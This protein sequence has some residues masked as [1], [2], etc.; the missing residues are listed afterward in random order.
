M[1]SR[2]LRTGRVREESSC[3]AGRRAAERHPAGTYGES[4]GAE[5]LFG[6]GPG[7]V[8]HCSE[9]VIGWTMRADGVSGLRQGGR[10]Q[11][12]GSP[13]APGRR[14]TVLRREVHGGDRRRR[15]RGR[16]VADA[17]PV[18]RAA[19]PHGHFPAVVH[20]DR[21]EVPAG[22]GSALL[23]PSRSYVSPPSKG[24]PHDGAPVGPARIDAVDL[25]QRL[26]APRAFRPVR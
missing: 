19:G 17:R 7:A 16:S 25:S 4:T 21:N 13:H 10:S 23:R 6:P 22:T 20:R 5:G 18:A 15:G 8:G 2:T 14:E 24:D 26:D 12:G 1:Y 9:G 11:S 3:P